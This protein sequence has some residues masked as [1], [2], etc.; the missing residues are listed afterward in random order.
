[1]PGQEKVDLMAQDCDDIVQPGCTASLRVG[2]EHRLNPVE[3]E[4]AVYFEDACLFWQKHQLRELH[5]P[6][7]MRRK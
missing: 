4:K 5:A 2:S 3:P 1:M 7:V 6:N